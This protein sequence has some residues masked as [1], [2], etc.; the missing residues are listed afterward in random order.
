M[1]NL[2]AET[3]L[4]GL[5]EQILAASTAGKKLAICGGNTKADIYPAAI[6]EQN[7]DV[8]VLPVHYRGIV[9]YQA[10]ELV[11]TARAGTKL[12][13]LD[14]ALAEKKQQLGFE[15]PKFGANATI[16]G[17][18]SAALSG[19]ARPYQGSIR[20]AVLGVKL[21]TGDGHVVRFGGEVMKNVAGYDVSRLVVGSMGSLALLLEVSLRV[22]PIASAETFLALEC[23]ENE[24]FQQM[25][26][27]GNQSLPISGLA[28]AD[29]AL[30]VRLSGSQIAVTQAVQTLSGYRVEEHQFWQDLNEQR[31]A[32]FDQ[33]G[34]LWRVTLPFHYPTESDDENTRI[35]DWGGGLCWLKSAANPQEITER[36]R[37][38]GG[39]AQLFKGD[40]KGVAAPKSDAIEKI[41]ERLR[42]V[43][44]PHHVF[45]RR[46]CW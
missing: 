46:G 30:H 33:P 1:N 26:L 20:D 8:D 31:L 3:E 22:T 5:R 44:D 15:P 13:E 27:L 39:D 32:F 4:K 18:V 37:Q 28:F 11:L 2:A 6:A 41:R 45:V 14:A 10:S 35:W 24:A 12:T 17:T 36:A 16:G 19:S 7:H 21:L 34:N 43:F 40:R 38:L 29:N 23:D 42:A 25:A 9:S